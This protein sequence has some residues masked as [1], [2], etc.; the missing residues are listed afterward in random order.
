M[1]PGVLASL[2]FPRSTTVITDILAAEGAIAAEADALGEALHGIIGALDDPALRP[3]LVGVRRAIHKQVSPRPSQLQLAAA[4]LPEGLR[5]RVSR[6]SAAVAD[7]RQAAASLP[8]V[9]A[10]ETAE[11]LPALR[12]ALA[13]PEFRHALIHGGAKVGTPLE[14]WLAG[15]RCPDPVT[16]TRLVMYLSRAVT[17]TS[18]FSSFTLV[19]QARWS[20]SEALAL[21]RLAA[22]EPRGLLEE[23]GHLL[24]RLATV[25]AV[26]PG[27]REAMAV[28]VNPSAVEREGQVVFL[29][30]PPAE[31]VS[32]VRATPAV[33][34]CLAAAEEPVTGC[35]TWA[36]LRSRLAG[37][38]GTGEGVD[39]FLDT[40]AGLGLL[41]VHL[42]VADQAGDPLGELAEW[43]DGVGGDRAASLAARC[44]DVSTLLR[45]PT[46]LDDVTSHRA[47]LAQVNEAI[48]RLADAAGLERTQPPPDPG[49]AVVETGAYAQPVADLSLPLWRPALDDLDVIRGWAALHD[50]GL[51]LRLA[52]GAYCGTRFGGSRVPFV[53]MY[54][55]L[56][57]DFREPGSVADPAVTSLRRL[58]GAAGARSPAGPE[59]ARGGGFGML[60]SPPGPGEPG[61]LRDVRRLRERAARVLS[62]GAPGED[63]VVRV[64]PAV[65]SAE[66]AA[67]P[68]WVTAP[69]SVAAYVQ[70]AGHGPGPVRLVLNTMIA[71][72]GRGC[73]RWLALTARAGGHHPQRPRLAHPV[74]QRPVPAE[75]PGLFDSALNLRE[76][77]TALVIDYPHVVAGGPLRRMARL[78]DLTVGEDAGTGLCDLRWHDTPVRPVHTGMMAEFLLPPAF[79]LLVRAFGSPTLLHPGIPLEAGGSA[80]VRPAFLP[81]IEVGRVTVRRATWLAPPGLLRRA[82]GESDAEYWLR[83]SRWLAAHQ[84][85]RQCFVQTVKA[86]AAGPLTW[87]DYRKPLFVDFDDWFMV[88][89][90]ERLL[91]DPGALVMFT[92]AL[93]MPFGAPSMAG[94]EAPE[95]CEYIIELTEGREPASLGPAAWPADGTS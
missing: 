77:S 18:P 35:L 74:A 26:D 76:P 58:L 51:A 7:R 93:P 19:G 88:K 65:L 84:A 72:Y 49:T 61:R 39:D 80:D 22:G 46:R 9:L 24:P 83:T 60:G 68:G 42:P 95:V 33:K 13:A 48:T 81:R 4:A 3:V 79:Q 29:G 43:L 21:H 64:D 47:R 75:S 6:F 28:R 45:Q 8:A 71:G 15:G 27:L 57:R 82:K 40:L 14:R 67:W 78:R 53:T 89:A 20:G 2:R 55:A 41:E 90:F 10:A 31:P 85:P 12:D 30:P 94:C 87:R 1:R 52:L 62:G 25:L 70:L 54:D 37:A 56:Q 50:P 38:A 91:R 69:G 17:K 36:E 32:R 73:S 92:E 86:A 59:S 11:R 66:A 63:G 34:A 23:R 16:L 44:R 5:Q